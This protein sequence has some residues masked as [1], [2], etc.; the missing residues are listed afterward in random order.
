MLSEIVDDG[1]FDL[2]DQAGRVAKH[3]T[4]GPDEGQ[5]QVVTNPN[6]H[7]IIVAVHRMPT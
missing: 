5:L 3:V 2:N 7:G 4:V 1:G 6:R